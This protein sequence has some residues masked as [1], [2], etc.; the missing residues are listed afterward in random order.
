MYQ[1]ENLSFSFPDTENVIKNISLEIK[2]GEFLVICGPSGCGKTTFLKQ[3]KPSLTLSGQQ[4]GQIT[5]DPVIQDDTKIGYVSQNPENQLVMNK[6]WH[7]IAFGLENQNIPLK[8]MKR[9]VGEIVNYLNLQNIVDCQCQDLSGGEKQLVNLAS[10][11]VMNPEVI[12]LD[13]ATAMLD[14]INRQEFIKMVQQINNDFG[15][16]IVFVEHQ[17]DDLIEIADRLLVM[18]HGEIVVLDETKKAIDIMNKQQIFLEAL[19]DYVKISKIIDHSSYSIKE[20]RQYI[21][22][23]QKVTIKE[24]EDIEF[25]PLLKI[26]SLSA[27]YHY[28]ILNQLDVDIYQNEV[29]TIVGANGSGKS[30]FIRCLAGLMKYEG[31]IEKVRHFEKIGYLPQD[32]TTLFLED[33]VEKDLLTVEDNVVNVVTM[34]QNMNITDLK[35][36]HPYDL[37]GGQRQLVALAKVLL[38]KPELLLLDEP[39]K[40]IDATAKEKLASLIV[41]LSKHMTIV[42]ISH[43]LEFSAKISDRVAMLFN[44]Q[45]KSIDTMRNFFKDNLFYTTTINKIMRQVNKEAVLLED[46]L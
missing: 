34:M 38:T 40:G 37:S 20:A 28:Q 18:D 6:V 25:V 8:Q 22:E 23:N 5:F 24:Y 44:G 4:K 9:R 32:P 41:A 7:E 1:I 27:G 17:L 35:D 30:T 12:L 36:Q 13:E 43:D 15:I 42:C 21:K 3:L 29:L 26:R 19:P 10:V 45:L 39:T 16:T 31:K 46:L 11:L 14:P 33:T 2:N